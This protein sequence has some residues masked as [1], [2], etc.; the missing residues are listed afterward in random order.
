MYHPLWT[1][2]NKVQEL[3]NSNCSW[4][5]DRLTDVIETQTEK[6]H[7]LSKK[8]IFF[9]SFSFCIFFKFSSFFNTLLTFY[10]P[11]RS[12]YRKVLQ[13]IGKL[14]YNKYLHLCQIVEEHSPQMAWKDI[15]SY[16]L[17]TF[18][19]RFF[20]KIFF[21]RTWPLPT[22]KVEHLCRAF[23]YLDEKQM[24]KKTWNYPFTHIY[25]KVVNY[26]PDVQV[27]ERQFYVAGSKHTLLTKSWF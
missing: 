10:H 22:F 19:A 15:W 24:C 3:A 2:E 17:H 7:Q 26:A 20:P 9:L 25:N 16:M 1:T 11:Y 18:S 8:F 4:K 21:P 6:K 5:H 27:K 23:T 13:P 14:L 12:I